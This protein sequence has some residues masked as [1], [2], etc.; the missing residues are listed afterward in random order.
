MGGTCIIFA[1]LT[2]LKSVLSQRKGKPAEISQNTACSRKRLIAMPLDKRK[3]FCAKIKVPFWR[4]KAVAAPQTR[5]VCIANGPCLTHKC[6]L[7][8]MQRSLLCYANKASLATNP[9]FLQHKTP[10]FSLLRPSGTPGMERPAVKIFYCRY[11][12]CI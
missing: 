3:R 6:A 2:A 4:E 10:I 8:V 12:I 1:F 7:I 5:L 9:H 11:N